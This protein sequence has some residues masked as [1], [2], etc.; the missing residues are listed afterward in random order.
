MLPDAYTVHQTPGRLRIKIPARKDDAAFYVSIKDKLLKL[1]GINEI[2]INAA[3]GSVLILHNSDIRKIAEYANSNNLFEVVGSQYSPHVT[4]HT[5]A[6]TFKEFNTL[7]KGITGMT[8]DI[9]G[10]VFLGLLGTGI[11][12]IGRGNF[13]APAW[14]TAFWYA[15]NIFLKGMPAKKQG[16]S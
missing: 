6:N 9:P 4:Y 7:M 14:Y 3:T 12:Q 2:K 1:Q 10:M 15:M 13:A 5:V 11:Y 16:F 8:L